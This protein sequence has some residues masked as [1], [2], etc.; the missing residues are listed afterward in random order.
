MDQLLSTAQAHGAP[1]LF[2]LFFLDQLGVPLPSAP[3]LLLLGALAGAGKIDPVGGLVAATAGSLCA[4]LVWFQLGRWKGTRV[5]GLLCRLSL[6][7]DS[8][9]SQT[10][11]LFE[12]H[13]V[14]SLLVAKFVPGFDTVAPPIAGLLGVRTRTFVLWTTGGAVVWIL[15]FGGA[16]YLLSDRIAELAARAESMGDALGVAVVALFGAYLAW[17]IVQRR[18]VLRA[19]RTARITPEQM[20]ELML[21][22]HDPVLVDARS[23][24]ALDILPFVIPGARL[25][26]FEEIDARHHEIPRDRDVIVYCS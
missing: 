16:G 11:G 24:A 12:R 22:G 6:E 17:K 23:A 10:Q 9:V 8:C 20:N 19:I 14:K 3:L 18:R 2:A 13:G 26:A 15:T 21:G 5:L 7:P 1:I 25:I 4:D